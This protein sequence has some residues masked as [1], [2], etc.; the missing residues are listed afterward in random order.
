M[1]EIKTHRSGNEPLIPRSPEQHEQYRETE[2]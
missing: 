2:G 1:S